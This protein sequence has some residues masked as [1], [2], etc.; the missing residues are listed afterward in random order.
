MSN[1][2]AIKGN[3][4]NFSG[5]LIL[6]N[7]GKAR[8]VQ[9]IALGES[10]TRFNFTDIT[11]GDKLNNSYTSNIK[12]MG[13]ETIKFDISD[14][15]VIQNKNTVTIETN[16]N[17][18]GEVIMQEVGLFETINGVRR[19]F[20][21]ASGFS[22]IKKESISYTLIID[23][24]LSLTFENEH[25]SRYN[26]AMNDAEYALAPNMN[27]L[28]VSLTEAQLDLER[29]IEINSREL[30]YNK[31]QSFML[32]QQ[33]ISNTLHNILLFGR[34][35]KS[36]ARLGIDNMTDC[37]YYPVETAI[38]Y[39]I[40]NLKDENINKYTDANNVWYTLVSPFGGS[41]HFVDPDGNTYLYAVKDNKE[42]FY[43][44]ANMFVVLTPV[45]H[46]VMTV[47]GNLQLCNRDNIDLS[48][49]ASIV[50]TT[51]LNTI[52]KENRI[53]IGKINPNE[54]EY[55][56]DFRVIYDKD[57][58]EHGLQF[59][60][61]SYDYIKAKTRTYSDEHKLVGHYRIKYFPNDEERVAITT[62]ETMFT[63]VYNGNIENPDIKMYINTT[64]VNNAVEEQVL[65]YAFTYTDNSG[66]H[67]IYANRDM[68]PSK[69]YNFDGTE[70][71]GD[72]FKII[73]NNVF[74]EGHEMSYSPSKNIST[75]LDRF[76]VDNFNYMGPCA[77]FK[78]RCTLRNYSQT[79]STD[80]Y[81]KPMYYLIPEVKN[82]S[83]LAFNRELND[84]DILYLS[85]ISKS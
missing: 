32:E 42:G 65:R 25:Y 12:V 8:I 84:A 16:L 20:A 73:N 74:Y 30:G 64:L 78:E 83:I 33:K 9:R 85:L 44:S 1:T 55:Y 35:E 45:P 37:F 31:A 61:Y 26:V 40:K 2:V 15:D 10:F 11:I 48:N 29:C 7:Y 5:R 41:K 70:Y 22:M 39:V 18:E 19:L 17:L 60:I 66:E 21:Y 53:I 13:N 81:Q 3:N 51:T 72:S 80:T 50:Y 76:I 79:K 46:S 71:E 62:N 24:S 6:T 38:N 52:Q 14:E 34:Y 82:S 58:D 28:F 57:R 75:Y 77:Q 36:I 69:L 59:T 67:I 23:L 43:R 56:F 47:N 4:Q 49:A 27:R 54:D 63:F 68:I